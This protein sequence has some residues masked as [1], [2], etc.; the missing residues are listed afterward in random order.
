M[1]RS[2]TS[3]RP[4]ITR[5]SR[6]SPLAGNI[7]RA[8]EG[9]V[10]RGTL[11][12]SYPGGRSWQLH[13]PEGSFHYYGFSTYTAGFGYNRMYIKQRGRRVCAFADGTRIEVGFTMDRM[14]N[15]L[16]GDVVH[17]VLGGYTCGPPPHPSPYSSS[18]AYSTLPR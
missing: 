14:N 11:T 2:C 16:W 18:S 6:L 12:R 10:L 8:A 1:A 3:S 17:E 4:A 13:G 5:R 9:A 15:V 7:P